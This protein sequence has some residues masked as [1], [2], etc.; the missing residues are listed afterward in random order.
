[1]GDLSTWLA[2][3][4]SVVALAVS[5]GAVLTAWVRARSRDSFT[6]KVVRGDRTLELKTD[7]PSEAA[8]IIEKFLAEHGADGKADTE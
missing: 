4:G 8:K 3:G 5:L 6:V 1:M 2:A 7:D